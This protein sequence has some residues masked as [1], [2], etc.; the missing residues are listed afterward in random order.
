[1]F[2]SN[3]IIKSDFEFESG[4]LGDLFSSYSFSFSLVIKLLD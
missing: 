1:M 2:K 3:L 4:E